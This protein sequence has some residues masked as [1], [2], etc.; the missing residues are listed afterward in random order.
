ML[1]TEAIEKAIGTYENGASESD[2]AHRA[3]K[4]CAEAVRIF[5]I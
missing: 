2:L 3:V 1:T 5:A 4:P